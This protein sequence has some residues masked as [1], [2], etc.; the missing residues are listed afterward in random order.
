MLL[1]RA[2][3]CLVA[4]ALLGFCNAQ[5]FFPGGKKIPGN[6]WPK[7][8]QQQKQTFDKPLTWT[9][10]EEPKPKPKPEVPF[11]QRHPVSAATVAVDCRESIA[12]VEVNKDFFGV[13]Q[14]INSADLT[15]G[16]CSVVAEDPIAQVLIFESQLQDCGSTLRMTGDSFIYTFTLNYNP[17]PLGGPPVVRTSSAAVI[18]ECHYPRKQNVSSLALEPLWVPFSA[19]KMAEEF[20]YFTLT[21]KT[22]DWQYDRPSYRYYLGDV[23]NIEASVKQYYHVPLRVF[24]NNCLATLSTGTSSSPRYAFIDQGCMIDSRIT[25]SESKFMVRSAENILNFQIE[26]FRFQ[27]INSGE[28]YITCNLKATSVNQPIDS[29]DRACSYHNGWREASGY[30]GACSSCESLASGVVTASNVVVTG[31]TGVLSGGGGTVNTGTG[32]TGGGTWGV[33]SSPK[34]PPGRRV[35]DVSRHDVLEWEGDVTLGPISIEEKLIA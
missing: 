16:Q 12:H 17:K 15:L 21:L 31:H 13:G 2:A 7:D 3:V 30:D 9:Y 6:P 10:P 22:D 24:V 8:P 23:I 29:D 14:M 4:L 28:M 11:Q 19:A 25:G 27:G 20:L 34:F 26:A 33:P 35:R 18:V 32:S 5:D 1:K